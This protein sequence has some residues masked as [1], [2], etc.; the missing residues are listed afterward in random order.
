MKKIAI[1]LSC[2]MLLSSGA[3]AQD[4]EALKA[5]KEAMKEAKNAFKKA[6]NTYE[7]SIPNAQYGR[8]ETDFE[9]LATA[10]PFLEQAIQSEYTR[11]DHDTWKIAASIELEYFK[12]LENET[13]ADPDNEAL[14]QSFI[15]SCQKLATYAVKY[16]SL[17]ALDKKIKPEEY[18][19][20]H[21]Q[22]QLYAV[23]GTIQ[24]LQA[25]QNASNSDDQAELAKGAKYAEQYLAIMTKSNLMKDFENK[26]LPS[27]ITYAKAFRAQSYL[28]LKDAPESKIVEAYTDLMSTTYKGIAYQSLAN[29]YSQKGD[30]AKQ[31]EYL[32][33]GIE[34][35][36][37]DAEQASSRA[38]FV[39]ILMQNCFQMEDIDGFRQAAEIMKTEYPDN[40]NAVNAYL[41]EGQLAFEGKDFL[42]AKDIFMQASEKYPSE[43]KGLLMAA[44]SA[45]MHAQNNGSKKDDMEAAI[46]LFKQ[47]EAANPE[48][49]ELWGE[50]LYIL[51]NNTQQS[52]LAAPYKKYYNASK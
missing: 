21:T 37:G 1:L 20:E 14:R 5:Q 32:K 36:K 3:N 26:D 11:D 27:W 7:M 51:Y 43:P 38:T 35:L 6:R 9:R 13:K 30:K 12:K 8:K 50:S 45:W 40:E 22:Y 28:N 52:A 39:V 34:A 15:A 16:D 41:M 48:D 42:K 10:L 25:A 2:L 49:P 31:N 29:Y 44:R 18:K 17:L 19:K 46:N 47:L 4:K 24:I 33:Q 23:N